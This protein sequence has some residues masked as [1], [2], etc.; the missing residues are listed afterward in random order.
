MNNKSKALEYLNI[1]R[2]SFYYESILDEK[3]EVLKKEIEKVL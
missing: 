3:D 2:S 1:P